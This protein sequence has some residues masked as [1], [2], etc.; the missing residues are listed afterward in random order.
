MQPKLG[1][2]A[3]GNLPRHRPTWT[4]KRAAPTR[5]GQRLRS[6]LRRTWTTIRQRFDNTKE[7]WVGTKP[8]QQS[9]VGWLHIVSLHG[10]RAP[11]YA[12]LLRLAKAPLAAP[13]LT[14]QFA[15]EPGRIRVGLGEELPECLRGW[16]AA[17]ALR[18]LPRDAGQHPV[19][20]VLLLAPAF[21]QGP[22]P[23]LAPS[24]EATAWRVKPCSA[25]RCLVEA[26]HLESQVQ[27][28]M[29]TGALRAR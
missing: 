19:L 7:G 11:R 1:H 21:A 2:Y 17:A 3:L 20:G 8:R 27:A 23:R 16:V 28:L 22:C 14:L 29:A 24:A 13:R 26:R 5:L 15:G 6:P 4:Q 10:H 18:D 25:Q 12:C 9:C